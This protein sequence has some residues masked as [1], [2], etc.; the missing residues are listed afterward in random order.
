MQEKQLFQMA[1]KGTI[2]MLEEQVHLSEANE[3]FVASTDKK[4]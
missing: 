3:K 1:F 2:A 4:K